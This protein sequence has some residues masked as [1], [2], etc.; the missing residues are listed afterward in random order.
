[1]S[2]HDMTDF[3]RRLIESLLSEKPRRMT[4]IDDCEFLDG[5][6]GSRA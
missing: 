5:T 2:Q 4:F 1:M 6:F 3:A